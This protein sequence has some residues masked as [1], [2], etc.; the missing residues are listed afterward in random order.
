MRALVL[1]IIGLAVGAF[2]GLTAARQIAAAH[3][4]PRGV[5]AVLQ[6]HLGAAKAQVNGAGQCDA[7]AT[8]QHL[9][10]LRSFLPELVPALTPPRTP[11]DPHIQQLTEAL[12]A[13]VD[14]SLATPVPADCAALAPPIRD[15]NQA[16][17]DCHREY[18]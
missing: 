5:M 4:Y 3:A 9:D 14:R 18:R 2:C 13:A 11:P 1:L 16:C 7:I 15:V 10:K 17:D 6:Q 12:G 8:R